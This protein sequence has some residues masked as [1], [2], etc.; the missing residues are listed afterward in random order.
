MRNAIKR[1][2]LFNSICNGSK[3]ISLD[4]IIEVNLTTKV[5]LCYVKSYETEV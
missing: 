5:I 2:D 3:N 1:T 4:K